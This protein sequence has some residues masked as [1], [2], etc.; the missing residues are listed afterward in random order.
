MVS[1]SRQLLR[2]IEEPMEVFRRDSAL[3]QSVV[4]VSI[5]NISGVSMHMYHVRVSA[6][7]IKTLVARQWPMKVVIAYT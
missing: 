4:S 3:M 7:I 5:L 2:R 6:T 1:W